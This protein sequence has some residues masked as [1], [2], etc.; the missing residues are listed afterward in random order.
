[1]VTVVPMRTLRALG[2]VGCLSLL[3]ACVVVPQGRGPAITAAEVQ[4]I[5][6]CKT[7]YL[8]I[9]DRFGAPDTVGQTPGLVTWKYARGLIVAFNRADIV[10]DYAH[11]APGIVEIKDRCA[12]Q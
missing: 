8:E 6:V 3:H 7:T 5:V 9:Q 1:M 2:T 11:N 10:V 12:T 4:Q